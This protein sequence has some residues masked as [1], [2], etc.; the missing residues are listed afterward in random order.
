M[1]IPGGNIYLF[2]ELPGVEVEVSLVDHDS[3]AELVHRMGDFL[4][5]DSDNGR[6]VALRGDGSGDTSVTAR[7]LIEGD[8]VGLDGRAYVPDGGQV[9]GQH[10]VPLLLL[11]VE[12]LLLEAL[13][14]VGGDRR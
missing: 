13:S 5:L 2:V 3:C 14:Q 12:N 4:A 7:L 6:G 10:V 9:A 1:N 11:I 8:G